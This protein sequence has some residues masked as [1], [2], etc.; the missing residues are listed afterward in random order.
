M[1]SSRVTPFAT[2]LATFC[3]C[4]DDGG[5]RDHGSDR[6]LW[7]ALLFLAIGRIML[8]AECQTSGA[9]PAEKDLSFGRDICPPNG[10]SGSRLCTLATAVGRSQCDSLVAQVSQAVWW[11][12]QFNW[13]PG[14]RSFGIGVCN[15]ASPVCRRG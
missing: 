6:Y 4:H 2:I 1:T 12:S 8:G 15:Q 9:T 3:G 14:C 13:I 5:H 10:N 7:P 11:T